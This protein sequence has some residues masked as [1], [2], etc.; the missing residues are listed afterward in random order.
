MF[1]T[2]GI[3]KVITYYD[4]ALDENRISFVYEDGTSIEVNEQEGASYLFKYLTEVKHYSKMD[5]RRIDRD[6]NLALHKTKEEMKQIRRD[7][8]VDYIISGKGKRPQ[9]VIPKQEEPVVVSEPIVQ[10]VVVP[11][12][13]EQDT[14]AQLRDEEEEQVS[15]G[16]KYVDKVVETAVR[17]KKT[18]IQ[19]FFSNHPRVARIAIGGLALMV[20]GGSP[21]ALSGCGR[22]SG[23][24]TGI[25]SEEENATAASKKASKSSSK[26]ESEETESVWDLV[27]AKANELQ[28]KFMTK[29]ITAARY[30]N[31]IFADKHEE[32]NVVFADGH[33]EEVVRF[34]ISP[35]EYASAFILGANFDVEGYQNF[36]NASDISIREYK[37]HF[38]SWYTQMYHAYAV[39]NSTENTG[40]LQ[41]ATDKDGQDFLR[42]VD[43]AHKKLRAGREENDVAKQQE[44]L[45]SLYNLKNSALKLDE[46]VQ[47]EA[48]YDNFLSLE[49]PDY[50]LLALPVFDEVANEYR[51]WT[52][53]N[54]KH[55]RDERDE[56]VFA[57]DGIYCHLYEWTMAENVAAQAVKLSRY[58]YE[59]DESYADYDMLM[60]AITEREKQDGILKDSENKN[61]YAV[62]NLKAVDEAFN[63]GIQIIEENT[64]QM[65]GSTGGSSTTT[66]TETTRTETSSRTEKTE[67]TV[68]KEQMT[69]KE[70]QEA[71]KQ[72][73]QIKDEYDKKNEEAKADA[74]QKADE[75][76]K[77]DQAA[78]DAK[79][80]QLEQ[81]VDNENQ[82]KEDQIENMNPGD[83]P[84][85]GITID[86]EH[87]DE[88]GGL[89]NSVKDPT[90]DGTGINQ[91][92]PDLNGDGSNIP[93]DAN[94]N[95]TDTTNPTPDSNQSG[96]IIEGE[97]DVDSSM[98]D[99]SQIPVETPTEKTTQTQ[100]ETSTPTTS[101]VE[102]PVEGTEAM[103]ATYTYDAPVPAANNYEVQYA[104]LTP[105][106]INAY[107]EQAVEMM[108]ANPTEDVASSEKVAQK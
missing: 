11:E 6:E 82:E 95:G 92:F 63:W 3:L 68:T 10:P 28:S 108:A 51:D 73:Q 46:A 53:E 42:A 47:L 31:K 40:L 80:D 34:G 26:E 18:L 70:K 91:P 13:V 62:E 33:T 35:E 77:K 55:F 54:G 94:Q 43:T 22:S 4:D 1:T 9:T 57:E 5:L 17:A 41:I 105:E 15:I 60:A 39:R 96:T 61:K 21:F 25:E 103:T 87:Q 66:T 102:V 14:P 45:N 64:A 59:A 67:E 90:T 104:E 49:L 75:D 97:V 44:A 32:K 50:V 74:E 81:E 78:E 29:S 12:V 58:D 84:G 76:A 8:I 56:K 89:D 71:E 107:A 48:T 24:Q 19:R 93:E 106:Q 83:K 30:F 86:Q 20:A 2:E 37:G 65:S 98:I 38:E 16:S 52:M 79:K 36:M 101:T 72:E 7:A 88:N 27:S 99:Q 69:D 85:D 23:N 100:P